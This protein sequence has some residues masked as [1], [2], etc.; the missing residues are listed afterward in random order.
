MR[1]VIDRWT[2]KPR[3]AEFMRRLDEICDEHADT[4]LVCDCPFCGA[5]V[6]CPKCCDEARAER[7]ETTTQGGE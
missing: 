1:E 4:R 2:G 3:P 7:E 5:P 6:C